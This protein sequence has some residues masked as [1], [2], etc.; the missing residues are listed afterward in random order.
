MP[1]LLTLSGTLLAAQDRQSS[2]VYHRKSYKIERSSLRNT[3]TRIAGFPWTNRA[4]SGMRLEWQ[5]RLR[6]LSLWR[7]NEKRLWN[8]SL[9]LSLTRVCLIIKKMDG[10]IA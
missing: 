3:Q 2:E 9:R 1:L 8:L 10:R 6:S 4:T 7:L 5:R